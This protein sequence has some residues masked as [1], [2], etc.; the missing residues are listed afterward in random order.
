MSYLEHN[1]VKLYAKDVALR[2]LQNYKEI[3]K[4]NVCVEPINDFCEEISWTSIYSDNE[5]ELFMLSNWND[6]K[7][8][9]NEAKFSIDYKEFSPALSQLFNHTGEFAGMII[10]QIVVNVL[11][12]CDTIR[13]NWCETITVT[14]KLID[15]LIEELKEV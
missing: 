15:N 5:A 8:A 12:E 4:N 11:Y 9:V 14:E 7:E 1:K 10:R 6:F 3:A 2:Y 13:S